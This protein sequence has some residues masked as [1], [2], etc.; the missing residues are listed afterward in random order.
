LFFEQY[1]FRDIISRAT[2]TNHL[3]IIVFY[4]LENH[5]DIS[6]RAIGCEFIAVNKNTL[7]INPHS[8]KPIP[9]TIERKPI[10]IRKITFI[11]TGASV[12]KSTSMGIATFN[13]ID[14]VNT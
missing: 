12:P 14:S 7:A 9:T 5:D 2:Y 4:W 6:R 3:T 13:S 10:N 11:Q 1:I 8:L